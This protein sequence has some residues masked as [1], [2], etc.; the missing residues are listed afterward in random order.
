MRI[1]C[2]GKPMAG[3]MKR[4]LGNR[5]CWNIGILIENESS[6]NLGFNAHAYAVNGIMTRNNIYSM[7]C[8]VA[9]GKKATTELEIE[10]K[11]LEKYGIEH[12]KCIDVL[13]W[14]YDNDKLYKERK[15]Q[16]ECSFL[17]ILK[18]K[19]V[20]PCVPHRNEASETVRGAGFGLTAIF[21]SHCLQFHQIPE[22]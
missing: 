1:I 9:A 10:D 22:V 19:S 5:N 18:C 2:I 17:S 4:D 13:F 6:L 11:F 8:D 20:P 14:V 12:I 3:S 16:G 7:D 21:D 15:V